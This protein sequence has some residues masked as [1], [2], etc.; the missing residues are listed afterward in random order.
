MSYRSSY[1]GAEDGFWRRISDQYREQIV[2]GDLPPGSR[3]PSTQ[4]LAV[5]FG[6]SV[7]SVQYALSALVHEGLLVRRPRHG[8]VVSDN[9]PEL[10]IVGIMVLI[11]DGTG[12]NPFRRALVVEL[13]RRLQAM[14]CE[15]VTIVE[16][17]TAPNLA[18]KI[19]GAIRKFGLQA[20]VPFSANKEHM[21]LFQKLNLPRVHEARFQ[22]SNRGVLTPRE[23]FAVLAVREL[24]AQGCRR[25][26]LV[27]IFTD[28]GL[29]PNEPYDQ[30]K[31]LFFE[32]YREELAAHGM[33]FHESLTRR[34]ARELH[35]A[36]AS[37]AKFGYDSVL[38]IWN[39]S[40]S[41]PDSLVVFT[42]ELLPGAAQA[43]ARL[44]LKVPENVKIVTHG[45]SVSEI[46][47][48][49][50]T[51][52]IGFQLEEYAAALLEQLGREF[53][54]ETPCET[55]VHYNVLQ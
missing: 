49:F 34:P 53:R 12:F 55:I 29:D 31:I 28:K 27:T 8:T 9:R 20:V 25:P 6:T 15:A 23:E 19:R 40:T 4:Q 45:N 54:R 14:G 35:H 44:G 1:E 33:E 30:P 38:D 17:G 21:A 22:G 18:D 2:S 16:D 39:K 47:V 42:D 3:L 5:D 52:R 7:Y 50:E 51:T 13:S 36:A 24:A 37:L 11:Y 26:A 46:F 10:K 43:V 48:P 32:R 41:A